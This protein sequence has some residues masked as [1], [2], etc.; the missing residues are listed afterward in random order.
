[1]LSFQLRIPHQTYN[2]EL[3]HLSL[4]YT[5]HCR[6]IDEKFIKSELSGNLQNTA[7]R[8]KLVFEVHTYFKDTLCDLSQKDDSF[9]QENLVKVFVVSS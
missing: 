2:I 1:M 4:A 5:Q 7:Q 8:D 3:L 9:E 6:D